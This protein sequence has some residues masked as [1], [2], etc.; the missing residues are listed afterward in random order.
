MEK[1]QETVTNMKKGYTGG[2]SMFLLVNFLQFLIS[3]NTILKI[4]TI[5][6]LVQNS[7]DT[8]ESYK[9]SGKEPYPT[10]T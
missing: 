9:Q 10:C 1:F 4:L 2:F 6:V 7:S 5:R 8:C 3:A